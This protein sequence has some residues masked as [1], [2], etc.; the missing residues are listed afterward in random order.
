VIEIVLRNGANPNI[1][2]SY[3][4]QPLQEEMM[5]GH[6]NVIQILKFEGA[7]L[8]NSGFLHLQSELHFLITIGDL[9]GTQK[10]IGSGIRM[11]IRSTRASGN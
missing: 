4:F 11:E 3:G 1:L 6:A 8:S 9:E 5:N 10:L 7:K 2:D